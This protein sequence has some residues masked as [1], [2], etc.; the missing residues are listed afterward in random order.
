MTNTEAPARIAKVH[1]AE[2]VPSRYADQVDHW[3]T[4]DFT[5]DV[6]KIR[7]YSR[8]QRTVCTWSIMFIGPEGSCRRVYRGSI[9]P[10]PYAALIPEAT[11]ISAVRYPGDAPRFDE[12]SE[13]DIVVIRGVAFRI[14]D[15]RGRFGHNPEL[16]PLT[17]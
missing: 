4:P 2:V 16:V 17:A 12:L 9:E 10:G 1:V 11:V 15:S 3:D 5:N 7:L 14:D 6:T 13:G 8:H